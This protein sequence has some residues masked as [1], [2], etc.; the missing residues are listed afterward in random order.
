MTCYVLGAQKTPND[1]IAFVAIYTMTL[2][3]FACKVF[4]GRLV[5]VASRAPVAAA[6][7]KPVDALG[8]LDVP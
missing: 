8:S 3:W 6:S 7:V 5:V 2:W 4:V 1:D